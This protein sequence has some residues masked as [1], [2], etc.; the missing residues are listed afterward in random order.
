[1]FLSNA[2]SSQAGKNAEWFKDAFPLAPKLKA[3]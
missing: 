2:D 3:L 1:V